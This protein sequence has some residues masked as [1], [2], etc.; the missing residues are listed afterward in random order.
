VR[1]AV[2]A[3]LAPELF[4]IQ[5]T[6]SREMHDKLRRAE[7]LLRHVVP[8]GDP[9]GVFDRA[10]TV[11]LADLEKRK[12][13][14]V[15]HPRA[16]RDAAYGSRR[17]PA[18]LKR[19]AWSRDGG[20]CTFIGRDGR[21]CSERGFLKYHHIVPFAVGGRTSEENIVL[22]CRAHNAHEAEGYFG[23]LFAKEA[24]GEYSVQTG[25]SA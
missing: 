16:P 24:R 13:A 18:S 1:R 17:I 9:A 8:S 2:V 12:C 25:L 11:L 4:K 6:M 19:K 5:F 23:P 21:R 7:D 14:T 3:P 22:M 15:A 20:R 10:L